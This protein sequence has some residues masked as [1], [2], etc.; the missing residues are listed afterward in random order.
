MNLY[1]FVL[2]LRMCVG[3]LTRIAR[4]ADNDSSVSLVVP[5]I[6][7]E[8][9]VAKPVQEMTAQVMAKP[10]VAAAYKK[11]FK[12]TIPSTIKTA[13]IMFDTRD[14]RTMDSVY[15][16][17]T[18]R[19]NLLYSCKFGY[20]FI[21]YLQPEEGA[22]Q[23]TIVV[24][25]GTETL[26]KTC[27]TCYLNGTIA[28][29]ASWCKLVAVADAL[30]KGYDKVV[31]VDSDAFFRSD[32]RSRPINMLV[33]EMAGGEN[34]NNKMVLFA[35]NLWF[36]DENEWKKYSPLDPNAALQIWKRD[37]VSWEFLRAWWHEDVTA[38]KHPYEQWALFTKFIKGF[39]DTSTRVF[40]VLQKLAWMNPGMWSYL[41]AIHI[42]SGE[43]KI[44][45]LL[46]REVTEAHA[47]LR[48]HLQECGDVA[49][50]VVIINATSVA[51]HL[52]D[53]HFNH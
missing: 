45:M 39:N 31:L 53:D 19:L 18:A 43:K 1:T 24:S 52:L 49:E 30:N 13:I 32:Y 29:G 6:S 3:M 16:K 44:R 25:E 42:K 50:H 7:T 17:Y 47:N 28:R 12:S 33:Q 37:P 15:W 5:K 14:P 40:G 26:A 10:A 8:L 20:D 4:Y 51:S 34:V 23:A 21:Y 2:S 27:T 11:S 22:E 36:G 41:P 35:T 9:T 48:E 38:T 46:L